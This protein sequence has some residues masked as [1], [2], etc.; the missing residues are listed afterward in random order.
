MARLLVAIAA[1]AAADDAPVFAGPVAALCA[2]NEY[3]SSLSLSCRTCA[4]TTPDAAVGVDADALGNARACRCAPGHVASLGTCADRGG[5]DAVTGDCAGLVCAACPEA[6]LKDRSACAACDAY[7]AATQD[8]VCGAD[9]ILVEV[10]GT[11]RTFSKTCAACAGGTFVVKT[12]TVLGGAFYPSDPYTCHACP[13]AR[14][15]AG[16][17]ACDTGYD[18]VGDALM[19]PQSCVASSQIAD[20]EGRFGPLA[21]ALRLKVPALQTGEPHPT[22][23]EKDTADALLQLDDLSVF[24]HLYLNSSARCL[25]HDGTSTSDRACQSLANLC[26]VA[27]YDLEHPACNAFYGDQGLRELRDDLHD[28]GGKVHLPWLFYEGSGEEVRNDRGLKEGFAF[29]SSTR[30]RAHRLELR[31]ATYALN[32]SFLGT[33][34]FS[35]D[36][37]YC[38]TRA[39]RTQ[40][41]GG[42]NR[43]T[44][45]T[46]FGRSTWTHFRCDLRTLLEKEQVFYDVYLVDPDAGCGD[47]CLYPIPVLHKNLRG[48]GGSQPNKNGKTAKGADDLFVRRFSF[49]NK[50]LGEGIEPTG[51][52]QYLDDIILH[53]EASSSKVAYV[54]TPF[55]ELRYRTRRTLDIEATHAPLRE[56]HIDVTVEYSA[57]NEDF[58]KVQDG[59]FFTL[60]A[61]SAVLFLYAY[62]VWQGNAYYE[63]QGVPQAENVC[64]YYLKGL[65]LYARLCVHLF[66]PLVFMLCSYWL[67]FFKL[68]DTVFILL[69]AENRQDGMGFYYYPVRTLIISLWIFQTGVIAKLV[70]DQCSVDIFFV[71]WERARASSARHRAP[72]SVWRT[73]FVAN[74]WNEMQTARKTNVTF[75]LLCMAFV[76]V[77]QKLENVAC[78]WPGFYLADGHH[79]IALRFANTTWWFFILSGAQWAWNYFFWERYISEPKA[80]QFLDLTTVAKV[81]VFVLDAE[82]HGWYLHGDAPFSHADDTMN[83]L[84]QHLINESMSESI[85]RGLEIEHPDLQTFQMWLTPAFRNAWHAV[86]T[87]KPLI[88]K[89]ETE[90]EPVA[91]IEGAPSAKKGIQPPKILQSLFGRKGSSFFESVDQPK[92]VREQRAKRTATTEQVGAFLRTFLGHGYA[93]TFDL[94]WDLRIPQI[95][96]RL[97]FHPPPLQDRIKG[98]KGRVIFQPDRPWFGGDDGWTCM[99]FLGHDYE[100]LMHEILTFAVVDLWF[101]NTWLSILVTFLAHHAVRVAR[102]VLG[103][104]NLSDRTLVDARFL[105]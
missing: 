55:L 30:N 35:S 70:V 88:V 26:V 38:E 78:S 102:S 5:Y 74:E 95:W 21:D 41:G 75:V 81:S 24:R 105:I 51:H 66:F 83:Q 19:G 58:E 18:L 3:Y 87:G 90:E 101:R 53:V 103:E 39:P 52:V 71:D 77:A 11:N 28:L 84:T 91:E 50:L 27:G 86:N 45:W 29:S 6:S 7:D 23:K 40:F 33:R 96:E 82:Y 60:V 62:R 48:E 69:P 22:S 73:L 80:Q 104:Q 13:D 34:P 64:L 98:A 79:N 31:A 44:Q 46:R 1:Y 16:C 9:E 65:L 43:D 67:I 93:E 17:S 89:K 4:P 59:L 57:P 14:M 94:D 61:V 10:E 2:A 54:N 85:G 8:C 12:D 68:Q 15:V 20:A 99:T 32:G 56:A 76:L 36:L 97:C 100:L 37:F 42:S 49:F 47:D 92:Q 25:Y 63:I 72:V